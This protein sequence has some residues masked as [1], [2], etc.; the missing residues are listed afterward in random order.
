MSNKPNIYH[1]ICFTT[2]AK[3]FEPISIL[4]KYIISSEYYRKQII[5]F[6]PLE[7][8]YKIDT[9]EILISFHQ[10]IDLTKENFDTCYLADS[11]LIIMDLENENTFKNLDTIINFMINLCD[12][13]KT[14][15]ILGLYI[16]NLFSCS[17]FSF[18]IF[19]IASFLFFSS[20]KNLLYNILNFSELLSLLLSSLLSSFFVIFVSF[21]F[22]NLFSV[23]LFNFLLFSE[24]KVAY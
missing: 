6:N 22:L 17:S 11:Y 12:I 5:K 1:V 21:L 2:N 3:S 8:H 13:E 14:I 19:S 10:I 15:F 7:F 23:E 20:S 16:Y 9:K 24:Y 4:Q 18:L